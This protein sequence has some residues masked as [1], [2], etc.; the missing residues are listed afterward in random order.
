[1]YSA[2]RQP[3][4]SAWI[5]SRPRWDCPPG[6]SQHKAPASVLWPSSRRPCARRRPGRAGDPRCRRHGDGA[7]SR[8]RWLL[9]HADRGSSDGRG[10]FRSPNPG[11]CQGARRAG[12]EAWGGGAV[13]RDTPR[14]VSGSSVVLGGAELPARR[15]ARCF[16][17]HFGAD[18]G[19][20]DRPAQFHRRQRRRL[21]CRSVGSARGRRRSVPLLLHQATRL[22]GCAWGAGRPGRGSGRRQ[23][24]RARVAVRTSTAEGSVPLEQFEAEGTEQYGS[25][26][27]GLAPGGH[28]RR[29]GG[30]GEILCRRWS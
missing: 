25:P 26:I 28:P 15:P 4:Q 2:A 1:M 29:A 5:L 9:G 14:C 20:R 16:L 3:A 17:R 10:A 24:V 22:C 11:P 27:T 18:T 8:L 21:G 12:Y 7:G 23:K 19:A 30:G 13:R 6:T